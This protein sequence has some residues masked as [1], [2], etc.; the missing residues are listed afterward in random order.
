MLGAM[1][2]RITSPDP[3]KALRYEIRVRGQLGPE[4]AEWFGG[5]A[6]TPSAGDDTLLTGLV[7]DQAAL[8]GVLKKVRDLGLP[9]LAVNCVEPCT[10]IP[11]GGEGAG[12]GVAAGVADKRTAQPGETGQEG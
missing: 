5:L 4:W 3:A 11:A 8:Y 10:E 1:D 7:V 9:L 6:V 2:A 12:G